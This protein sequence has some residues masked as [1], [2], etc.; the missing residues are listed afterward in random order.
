MEF[1]CGSGLSLK[2][3]KLLR[4]QG[5]NPYS[6]KNLN[7]WKKKKKKKKEKEKEKKWQTDSLLIRYKLQFILLLIL[8]VLFFS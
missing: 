7:A 8:E 2:W 5:L 1:L 3:I 6:K 4:G